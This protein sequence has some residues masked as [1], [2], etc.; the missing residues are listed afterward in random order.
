M[1]AI[2]AQQNIKIAQ[3]TLTLPTALRA[4]TKIF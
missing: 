2:F 4:A 3:Q 1:R